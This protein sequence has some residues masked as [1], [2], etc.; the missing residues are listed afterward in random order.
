MG[1]FV[2]VMVGDVRRLTLGFLVVFLLVGEVAYPQTPPV[3]G[4]VKTIF[5][6]KQE[7]NLSDKQEQDIKTI[8]TGLSQEVRVTRAKLTLIDVEAT[9]LIKKDGDLELI[10]KKLKDAAD[11][12]VDLKMADIVATRKIN[13][14]LTP[15]QLKKWRSL[16]ASA[17]K[18]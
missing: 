13:Q 15:E 17:G 16:Q 5:D 4:I 11:I 12:Q 7:L 9:D 8:L 2:K 3:K 14:V 6:Y 18:Q 10:R 1:K